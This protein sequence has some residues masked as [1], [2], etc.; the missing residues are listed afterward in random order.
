[1]T[2]ELLN[3]VARIRTGVLFVAVMFAGTLAGFFLTYGFTTMPGLETTDDRT[4]VEAFQG[5]ER[6]FGSFDFGINWPVI[7]GYLGSPVVIVVAIA[8]HRRAR[9]IV[10]FLVA[11]LVLTLATIAVTQVV[12][13]PLNEA[14]SAAGDPS[15]I[16]AAQVRLE[17]RESWWRGWNLVRCATSLGAFS[18]LSWALHLGGR[19]PRVRP[20]PAPGSRQSAGVSGSRAVM[21]SR[22][23]MRVASR[24]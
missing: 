4:F 16:Q 22:G 1:M 6:M 7:L 13:V 3:P 12:H 20:G 15:G 18:F 19:S 8:L 10:W 9:P 23:R 5:L 11:A 17:F 14:I 21:P 2:T 24:A